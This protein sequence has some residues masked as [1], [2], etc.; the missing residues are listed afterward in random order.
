MF[1]FMGT[2]LAQRVC[3]ATQHDMDQGDGAQVEARAPL[4]R[5][6]NIPKKCHKTA[7]LSHGG[8]ALHE[9]KSSQ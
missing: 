1:L 9:N 4:A 3:A 5:Q 8:L 6:G 2:Q 7:V